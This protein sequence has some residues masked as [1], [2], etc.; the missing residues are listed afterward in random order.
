M[1]FILGHLLS[2]QSPSRKMQVAMCFFGRCFHKLIIQNLWVPNGDGVFCLRR[3]LRPW[4][5]SSNRMAVEISRSVFEPSLSGHTIAA[6]AS[7]A[8]GTFAWP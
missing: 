5:E 7:T 4:Y 1:V 6:A 2:P 8:A 3:L